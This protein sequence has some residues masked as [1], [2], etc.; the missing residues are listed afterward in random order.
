MINAIYFDLGGVIVRTEDKTPRAAL[1]AEFGMTYDE[2]DAFVFRC[3][4]AKLASIGQISEQEHWRE[5]ARRL[6]L[7]EAE[8]PRLSQAFFAGDR[9]DR[10]LLAFIQSLRPALKT[11]VISNAWDGL[12]AYM[13]REGFLTPFDAVIISAEVGIIKPDPRIYQRALEK[14]NIDAEEAIFVDDFPENIAA[15]NA[16]GMRGVHFQSAAQALKEIQ[17]IL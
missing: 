12:R 7:P 16:L 2:M 1:G 3:Q 13:L 15:A 9:V 8:G 6:N 10:E 17:Q 5:V 14:L 4:T 11:G